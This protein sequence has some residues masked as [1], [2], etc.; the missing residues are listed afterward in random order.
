MTCND[1]CRNRIDFVRQSNCQMAL[2]FV[3]VLITAFVY[4]D[5]LELH[6]SGAHINL[7][8]GSMQY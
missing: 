2:D 1:R 5:P 4:S 6:L 3:E 8:P 7:P